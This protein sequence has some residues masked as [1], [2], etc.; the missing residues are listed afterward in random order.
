MEANGFNFVEIMKNASLV[1]QID[2]FILILFSIV[3]WGIILKKYF[4]L[5]N[6]KK[7]D[8]AFYAKFRSVNNDILNMKAELENQEDF[9][10][11]LVFNSGAEEYE[12]FLKIKKEKNID[13]KD[14]FIGFGLISFSR[15]LKHGQNE[16]IIYLKSSLTTL[17][18]IGSIAPFVGLFGTVWGI[19]HSFVGLSTASA[20]LQSVAPG[21]AE[22][23]IATAV[24]LVAAIPAVWFYNYFDSELEEIN[25]YMES[26]SE[27]FVN[28]IER[29]LF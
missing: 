26:F 27:S 1:V 3:S 20:S 4:Q 22:A 11:K 7:V 18:S 24:G 6:F 2:F 17:A 12:N 10:L 21:I 5:K 28:R 14:H 29:S 19:I 13:L 15:A 23:L 8:S 9:P 16:S 25:L